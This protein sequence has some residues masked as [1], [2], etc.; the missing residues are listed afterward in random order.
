MLVPWLA[1][2]AALWAEQENFG[3]LHLLN[4]PMWLAFALTLLVL[5]LMIYA[6]HRLMHQATWL[7]R[8]HRLHHSDLALDVSS[9]MRFHPLE[10]LFSMGLKIGAVLVLGAPPMAV[11]VFAIVLNGLAM[12]THANLALPA[13]FDRLLRRLLVTPDMHRIHHSIIRAEQNSNFGFNLSCWDRLF[14]SYRDQPQ[15]PQET[16]TL[17]LEQ[18]RDAPAQRFDQLLLQPFRQQSAP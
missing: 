18:F 16:L 15:Q 6:Q 14:G 3:L 13:S 12:F 2:D 7:W 9:A 4:L 11:L 8:M 1:V 10:I 17:G 5:D